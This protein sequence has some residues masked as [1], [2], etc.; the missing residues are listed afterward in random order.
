VLTVPT[1][2]HNCAPACPLKT[3][4]CMKGRADQMG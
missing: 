3:P 2:V 1:C 4:P